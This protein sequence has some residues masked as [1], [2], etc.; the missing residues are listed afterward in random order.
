[1]T[2]LARSATVF[3]V[4]AMTPAP[5]L[6]GDGAQK[7]A[8]C[9]GCHGAD[10]NSPNP[11][12]PKLAGQHAGYLRAQATA[13]RDGARQNAMMSPMAANLTDAD[14]ADIADHFAAQKIKPGTARADL[15]ATGEQLYRGGNG[16]NGIPA[17][18]SCHSPT[19]AGNPAAGYPAVG[20]QH[21]VYTA[22]QLTAY[23]NGERTTDVNAVMRTIAGR[24]SAAEIEAVA[25]YIE[26]LH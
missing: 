18:M 26:G 6:A 11:E 12:W 15:V 24:M 16:Q 1:M 23:K 17:C 7:A 21:A 5:A 14:I 19:G 4:L 25:S 10:G 2:L 9:A 20:G 13:F 22:K 3:L 8:V